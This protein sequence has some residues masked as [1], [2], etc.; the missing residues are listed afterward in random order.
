MK[1]LFFI[2]LSFR[3]IAS[4]YPATLFGVDHFDSFSKCY[5]KMDCSEKELVEDRK[6][7]VYYYAQ[8]DI[9]S[10]CPLGDCTVESL[11][12][13]RPTLEY[14]ARPVSY[15]KR[16]C[17]DEIDEYQI[18]KETKEKYCE[19][20]AS[21]I[22]HSPASAKKLFECQKQRFNIKD[23]EDRFDADEVRG[24]F[25]RYNDGGSI[26]TEFEMHPLDAKF[27]DGLLYVLGE[28]TKVPPKAEFIGHCLS[29]DI[30]CLRKLGKNKASSSEKMVPVERNSLSI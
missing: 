9:S 2:T 8:V 18:K 26:E 4:D 27:E 1:L 14:F 20:W 30:S 3:L 19:F 17:S 5:E 11:E 6:S 28:N 29:Y 16:I 21:A 13:M 22:F 15:L 7:R 24:C 25:I 12:K 10:I 23:L